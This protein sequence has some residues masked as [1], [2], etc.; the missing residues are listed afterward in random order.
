MNMC[1]LTCLLY[2]YNRKDYDLGG[3]KHA[4]AGIT[5]GLEM[6]LCPYYLSMPWGQELGH[7]GKDI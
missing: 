7:A 3:K 1:F 6:E 2:Q 4:E 5:N